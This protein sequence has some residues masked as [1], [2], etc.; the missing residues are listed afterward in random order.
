MFQMKK[1]LV[2]FLFCLLAVVSVAQVNFEGWRVHLPYFRN[3]SITSV[4]TKVYCGSNSGLFSYDTDDGSI[5]RISRIN[6]LSDVEVKIVKHNVAKNVS[7]VIYNNSNIDII[8]ERTHSIYNVPDILM[9]TIIGSKAINHLCFFENKVYLACSFGI[10]VLDLDKRQIIDSY[11]NLGVGGSQLEFLAISIFNN[12]I[13]ASSLNGIYSAPLNSPNLNDF[14][15]WRVIK[16]STKSG[17]S[18]VYKN[19]LYALVDDAL[20][21]YDGITWQLYA[22]TNGLKITALQLSA[23]ESSAAV[24]YI[25]CPEKIIVESGNNTPQSLIH[26]YR[27]DAAVNNKGYLSMVDE[28]YGLTIDNKQ[29]QQLDYIIPN[30]PVSKTFGRML[31]ENEKLWVAGGSV[32]DRWDPLMYNGSKFYQYQNNSWFNF[33][34]ENTPGVI[35][36]SDFIDIKKNPYGNEIYL[37][38]YG[39]GVI[40]M[41]NNVFVKKYDETNS[42]LQRLSVVDPNF[43]PLLSGGMDFDNNGNLWVS[44][45]GANKPLSV[46]TKSGWY[47]FNIGNIAGGNELGWVT[48]DD[49]N[50]KWVL[51]LKDKGI[52]VY[53]DNGSPANA[54]DDKFKMLTKEVGQGALPSNTVLCASKDL[55]GEM[56]IGTSQGLTILSNPGQ[57]FNTDDENFDARP[58][59]IKVG[60]NY[61]IFLGKEQINCIKVDP[62]NRKWIGTPNGVWLVS[63]DGYKVIKN[64]TT[65][66]SPL[67]SN[68][69]MEI[70]IDEH[71]G[72]VFFGTEKGIISY[73]GDASEGSKDFGKV[74][75][76]PNPVRPEF[77]GSIAIR[78]LVDKATV[79]ITDISGN[80]VYETTANG[81]FAS[82]DGKSFNGKRVGTGVYVIFSASKDGE[83]TFAGKLLFIN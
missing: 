12:Q 25:I 74:E 62:S 31:Y 51:S 36:M 29:T 21:T 61:E 45:F 46:K 14:N 27:S 81:G 83:Q 34:E 6:G 76:Y 69:V 56:W 66:N 30:G 2:V 64:F 65:V 35:G 60:S 16:S 57:I 72:E 54:N 24:M 23:Y 40:E 79:K 70:G 10:V 49:Y 71:T 58:I 68:N 4:G 32:N 78:G 17:N 15:F 63:D 11:Q 22:P 13:I 18:L 50:N 47:A 1:S 67:L 33:T 73:M 28:T 7:V 5:E 9:K 53:N 19:I 82:W 42:T 8:D 77:T 37:T 48:C 20:Q 59:V 43:K 52:L 41:F 75:I 39:S 44:N 26:T 3:A 80:L 38:S 55:R